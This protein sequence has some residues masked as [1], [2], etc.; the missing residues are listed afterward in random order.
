[1][2]QT[3]NPAGPPTRDQ[4]LQCLRNETKKLIVCM[5]KENIVLSRTASDLY[6]R[7]GGWYQDRLLARKMHPM[8]RHLR[9]I[10]VGTSA[11]KCNFGA[12]PS[13]QQHL[14]ASCNVPETPRH[15]FL[16]CKKFRQ[17][18]QNFVPQVKTYLQARNLEVTPDILLGFL[19]TCKKQSHE[20]QTRDVREAIISYTL[21]YMKSTGR[22]ESK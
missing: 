14:C 1:M 11:L 3:A 5:Q 15:F 16:D 10:R 12:E 4:V 20:K 21:D 18:R 2:R 19:P 22:F 7:R 17:Q 9:N 6:S 8:I 13:K